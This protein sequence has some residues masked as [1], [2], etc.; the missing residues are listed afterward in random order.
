M[1]L[2]TVPVKINIDGYK[3]LYSGDYSFNAYLPF[4]GVVNII[5]N[6]PRPL[7]FLL[8]DGQFAHETF[9]STEFQFDFL[10]NMARLKAEKG[11]DVLIGADSGSPC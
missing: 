1:Y 3:F 4:S 9:N 5:K 11:S 10:R 8:I 2:D 6:I 7:D